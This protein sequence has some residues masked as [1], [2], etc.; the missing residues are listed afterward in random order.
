MEKVLLGLMPS[1]DQ[2]RNCNNTDC[3]HKA[4]KMEAAKPKWWQL[5]VL[6]VLT[7]QDSANTRSSGDGGT[8]GLELPFSNNA[9][10]GV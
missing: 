6:M 7:A 9:A 3:L 5:V 8:G 2:R 4:L 10:G 1:C